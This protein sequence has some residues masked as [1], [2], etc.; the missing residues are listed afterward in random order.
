[1]RVLELSLR[2]YRIFEEVDLELPARV[3][4]IFGVNGSGKSTLMESIAFACYGVDA[5]RT[6]KQEIR[7]HGV[8]TDC[9]VRLVFEHAGQPYEVRRTISGKGHT[10][11]AELFGGGMT[12]ATGTV[13]V[14]AEIRRLLHMDLQVFRASVYAEQKQLDAFSDVTAGKRKE[15]ALRLLGIRPVEDARNA[16]RREARA[17]RES[18]DQLTG[19]VPDVAA[20]EA[21]LKAVKDVVTEAKR[22]AKA[23]A[24]ELRQAVAAERAVKKA[25]TGSDAVRQRIEKLTIELRAKTEQ[26]DHAAEQHRALVERVERMNAAVAELPAIDDELAGLAGIDDRLRLGTA[27]VERGDELERT[28][29]RLD[30]M[31]QTDR[32][33]VLSEL[34]AASGAVERARSAFAG[35]EAEHAHR[36]T[37]LEQALERLERAA[38]ADP[39]Q[40]CPTCGRPMGD[41]FA[42]YV[43][44]CKAEVA[45]AKK[46]AATAAAA[47]RKALA[48]RARAEK[49]QVA[50]AEAGERAREQDAHRSQ[51]AER[52]GSLSAEVAT[53]AEPFDGAVPELEELRAS[54]ERAR[55]LGTR[56]AELRT[57]RHH[58]SQAERDL[59]DALRRIQL[60]DGELAKLAGEAEGLAFDDAAHERLHDELEEAIAALD[61]ARE[62]ERLASDALKDAEKAEAGLVAA[63]RQAKE[64]QARLDELRSDARYAERVALLLEGF[65]NHLVARIGPELSREAEALFRELTNHE[66]DDLK[67]D[68]EKLTIQIADGDSYF[69]IDRFSGSETDLANLALRVAISTQLSRLSG[70]DVGMMVLDEVLASLDEER[71]DLMVQALGRLSSRFHQLFVVTHAEQIKDQFPATISVQKVGRRRSTAVL[72]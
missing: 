41:D 55:A 6:R 68:E 48:E 33:T 19:A 36:S 62:A 54:A 40:P 52:I 35:A 14:D 51:L 71:K 5:A 26:R 23:A 38:E 39:S 34:E 47:V 1:M 49:D 58:L 17:T 43:K 8:L 25:F 30:A 46:T 70:A 24:T 72:V 60:L 2:N 31:P 45:G 37:L 18:A 42:S 69:A 10:P 12:L 59:D 15:M 44:H 22:L 66:Y 50:A 32:A 27:L 56:A 7:T 28:Q 63:V 13:E 21:D 9:E 64:T 57:E 3:I 61:Q 16:S 67:V 11:G 20:L 65:R 53:L 29:A 4:G